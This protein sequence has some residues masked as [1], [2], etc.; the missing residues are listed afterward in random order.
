MS[1]VKQNT[2]RKCLY[3]YRKIPK[4][5]LI[6]IPYYPIINH[7]VEFQ[8]WPF[9]VRSGQKVIF[10]GG[11]LYKTLG[12]G[13][14]YYV[15]VDQILSRY[16]DVIFWYA[17]SGDRTEIDKIISK[18]PERAYITTERSDLYQV[19][20]H[21]Y[22]Y[23]STYPVC[24]GL[25]FQYAAIAGKPPVTLYYDTMTD[26]LLFNQKELGIMFD[27]VEALLAE[28]DK[29][30]NDSDY[31]ARKCRNLRSSVISEEDFDSE[32]AELVAGRAGEKYKINYDEQ[33][34]T[35]SFRKIYLDNMTAKNLKNMEN[36]IVTKRHLFIMRYAPAFF[37]KVALRK[38]LIRLINSIKKT[39]RFNF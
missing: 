39:L 7:N 25:M 23:L 27:N 24:G 26:G 3:E 16:P 15:V 10:S 19:L 17:G 33:I 18:Y 20:K 8:G 1:Y 34:E 30:M 21:C 28:V 22:F 12:A 11:S 32:I 29:L 5:K 2:F 38:A 36:V 9:P 6:K 4:G 31:Y 37:T 13:N 14:K 35:S